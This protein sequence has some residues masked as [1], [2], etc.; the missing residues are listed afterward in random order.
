M[1]LGVLSPAVPYPPT[2]A[3]RPVS[4]VQSSQ[5]HLDVCAC[6]ARMFT[7]MWEGAGVQG[8][9]RPGPQAWHWIL[10]AF[11]T[12]ARFLKCPSPWGRPRKM[13]QG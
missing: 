2:M 1:G 13:A 9:G 4:P 5:V 10:S 3:P 8:W 12:R 6:S 11:R 7:A